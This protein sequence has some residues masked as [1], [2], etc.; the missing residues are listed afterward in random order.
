MRIFFSIVVLLLNIANLQAATM[1]GLQTKQKKLDAICWEIGRTATY[2]TMCD[3]P[4]YVTYKGVICWGCAKASQCQPACSGGKVCINQKCV[5]PPNQ[6][7]YDCKGRCIPPSI[8][9]K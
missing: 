9:C 8:P 2:P 3:K 6:F 5:C 7:L 4:S 1:S